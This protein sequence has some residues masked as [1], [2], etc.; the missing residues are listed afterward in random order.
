MLDNVSGG[1]VVDEGVTMYDDVPETDNVFPG[2]FGN[3]ISHIVRNVPCSFSNDL[4][5]M[6][7]GVEHRLIFHELNHG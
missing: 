2:H 6:E 7:R 5:S 4:K 3:L 1:H